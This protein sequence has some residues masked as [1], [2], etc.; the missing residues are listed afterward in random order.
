L[1]SARG[2]ARDEALAVL[3]AAVAQAVD[4]GLK[5]VFNYHPNDQLR[6]YE[7]RAIEGRAGSPQIEAYVAMAAE[8]A[9]MLAGFGADRVAIEPFNEPAYYPCDSSGSGDWQKI[10]ERQVAAIRA[11][12]PDI[13]IVVTGACGGDVYGLVDLDAAA[14]DDGNILYSFHM[15]EPHSFTHQRL[16]NGWMSGIPWPASARSREMV[17]AELDDAM[18]AAGLSAVERRANRL[19]IAGRVEEYYRTGY[20]PAQMEA[21]FEQAVAWAAGQGIAPERLFVGEFGVID[22]SLDG[23]RGAHDADRMRYLSA[24][25]A[26]AERHGMAWS[27]WEYANPYGM[28]FIHPE[29]PALPDLS[30]IDALG[31]QR[32][33]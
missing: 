14:F 16:E 6:A 10:V 13:T 5:V 12:A 20:G 24:V 28:S 26:L 8:T 27:F 21:L 25:V 9:A 33:Q 30:V 7:P 19:A 11:V 15:Y 31:L 1:L 22:I 4:A 18:A 32:S 3:R 23:R 17:L 29:G 2:A